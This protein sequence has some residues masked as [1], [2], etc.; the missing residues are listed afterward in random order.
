M[1]G[2]SDLPP[3]LVAGLGVGLL[4]G[5]TTFSTFAYETVRLAEDGTPGSALLNV[6][7]AYLSAGVA[8]WVG[9]TLVRVTV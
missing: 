8:A 6:L 1:G 5:F 7:A 9:Y 4:G 2:T 3:T